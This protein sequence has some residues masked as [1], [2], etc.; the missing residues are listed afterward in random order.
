MQ[1]P[2]MQAPPCSGVA[3]VTF[4]RFDSLVAGGEQHPTRT[5][6]SAVPIALAVSAIAVAV[7]TGIWL[8]VLAAAIVTVGFALIAIA[9]L[10]RWASSRPRVADTDAPHVRP[11]DDGRHRVL[12]IADETCS[13]KDLAAELRARPAQEAVSV[14]V[15]APAL[16]SRAGLLADDQRGFDDAS[17]HLGATVDA[18]REAGIEAD[19]RIG[20]T[21]PLQSTDDGL[22]QFPADEIVIATSADSRAGWLE[23]GLVVRARQRYDQPVEHIVVEARS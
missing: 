17:R 2:V 14:F 1:T 7:F 10:V 18:L 21:D 15:V 12:L 20:D 6:F 23:E 8:G 11:L 9:A 16:E 4:L 19:G 22:R 13:G 5:E 3:L